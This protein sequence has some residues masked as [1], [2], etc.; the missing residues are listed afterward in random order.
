M[1][2][3]ANTSKTY[4][5]NEL[6]V[7]NLNA[8]FD[9][10]GFANNIDKNQFALLRLD[11]LG[12]VHNLESQPVFNLM[13]EQTR[14]SLNDLQVSRDNILSIQSYA[15]LN[16]ELIDMAKSSGL[17]VDQFCKL[18]E[19]KGQVKEIVGEMALI[20]E[21]STFAKYFTDFEEKYSDFKD[22][23]TSIK[24]HV[25][26][27]IGASN[28]EYKDDLINDY[29]NLNKD[30]NS[31]FNSLMSAVYL[32]NKKSDLGLSFKDD[33]EN[34]IKN[35]QNDLLATKSVNSVDRS[36]DHNSFDNSF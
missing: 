29:K 13:V 25:S 6:D 26:H 22:D 1:S 3:L 2:G 20:S 14:D 7:D 19:D 33:F 4:Q 30:F 11:E 24:S 12:S 27:C 16:S 8:Y 15:D 36:L 32:N 5:L 35:G 18:N 9:Q 23:L 21:D 17:S 34:F 10:S 31:G 28:Q